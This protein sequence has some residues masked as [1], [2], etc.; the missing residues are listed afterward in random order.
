MKKIVS[1]LFLL[2]SACALN[3]APPTRTIIVFPFENRSSNSDLGWMSEAFA[4]VLSWRLAGSH[5]FVLGRQEL[6]TAYR[7]LGAPPGAT[8][9]LASEYKIAQTLGVDWAVVG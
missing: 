6:N 3:A 2:L 4:E 5:R 7:Q 1:L 8:L 9:T